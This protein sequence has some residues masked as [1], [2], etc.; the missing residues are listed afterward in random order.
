MRKCRLNTSKV[1][2]GKNGKE[3]R[4]N[5]YAVS[6]SHSFS[7]RFPLGKMYMLSE[8]VVEFKKQANYVK[9]EEFSIDRRLK[10]RFRTIY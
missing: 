5:M 10:K 7:C 9:H 1:D 4:V 2:C 3:M 8:V 6:L